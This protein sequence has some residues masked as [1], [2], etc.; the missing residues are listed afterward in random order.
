MNEMGSS[1]L[2][3]LGDIVSLYAEGTVSGFLSTLGL[4]DDRSVVCPE[5]GDLSNPPKKFRD[6][7]FKICPMNRYSAQKQFWKAAKQSMGSNTDTN[8]LKRLHHAAEIE[9]KQNETENKK[10]LGSN[11]QYGS[12]V[13]LLHL[14]SNKYLTVN[15]RLP[16]LLE[17]NAMRVYL[18]GNGNEGSWFYI[19]PFYK[20][21]ATGDNI[22]LGDKVILNPVNA[23]QQVLHVAANHELPDNPGCKEVNVV[24]G[25]TSWKVTLFMEHRENSDEILKG[26]DVVRLF[27]AEQEKFLT[28][29]EYKKTHHVFLRTT[30]RTSA[31]AATS[32]KALWE[33]EVVQHDPCRGG[34][35][36]W[37]SLFRFKHLATGQY[38]AADVDND[39]ATDQMR[40]KLRADSADS[41]VYHLV[42]VAYPNEI[43]SLFELDPT[44]LTRG[45][46]LV[47]Q[48]SYVRLHHLFTNSWVHSTSIPIDKDEE[49]PVMSKVGC[50]VMKE[51][52]EAF[53]LI[54]VSPVEVRDLDFANDACKLLSALSVK[55]ERGTISHNERRAL[56]TL[57]QDI[58]YFVAELENEQNKTEALELVVT[59]PN[60]DRPKLLREQAILKQLFK[61]LQ[62][63]PD[64]S[65]YA[66]NIISRF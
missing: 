11:V 5:A 41:A 36:H 15:K 65:S 61:I 9:K 64:A 49:K 18:D 6:C 54:S 10:L 31:T 59:N 27:H 25:S 26:G 47:P 63:R 62:V 16:A 42:P 58:V 3:H 46:S 29:D 57:L 48:S 43:A 50:A 39:Q 32:S 34:A 35:G 8:L 51:D 44:S 22:V 52:K 17:K 4:V 19:L 28:M 60:R 23:G 33:V 38:L 14:K 20:L 55:L 66:K 24:N 40:S 30:G 2:L 7:L 53:A 37:D 12:V 13:Q 56:T 21:R 1:S 45:D